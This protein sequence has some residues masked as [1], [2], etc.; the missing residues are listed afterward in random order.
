M[1]FSAVQK[2]DGVPLLKSGG[3]DDGWTDDEF[4]TDENQPTV[5][6][7]AAFVSLAFINAALKRSAWVC[8]GVAVI[9]LFLGYAAYAKYPPAASATTSVLIANNPNLNPADQSATDMALAKS[10]GV[11]QAA[12]K[13]LGLSQSVSS[14]LAAY[15]VTAS[16]DEVL[17]FQVSGPSSSS[18][19]QRAGA[20]ADAFLQARDTY[21]E[22]QQQLQVA[23]AQ[24]QL[25]QAQKKVES[26]SRQ[27]APL[28]GQGGASGPEL[29]TLQTEQATAQNALVTAQGELSTVQGTDAANVVA[30]VK[31]SQI[32]NLPTPVKRT[33]K[34]SKLFYLVLA[35]IAGLA[36]GA[37]IVVIQALVSSR[38]RNRDDIADAIGAPIL[39]S[40]GEVGVNWLP[41]VGRRRGLRA[42]DGRRV[43][44][45][46]DHA[47]EP[48]SSG[49]SAA[50]A[51][52]AVDNAAE[53]A[54]AV[55]SLALTWASRG[56][57]VVL[58]DLSAGAP[59][60]HQLRVK[61]PGVHRASARGAELVVSVPDRDDPAPVGPRP[62]PGR[63]QFGKVS[64]E[65]AKACSSADFLL[66]L[67]TL[68]PLS[69]SDHLGSWSAEAVA[70]V[71]A[72]Q[73]T[74]TRIRAVGEMVRLA[75]TRLVSVVLLRA[76]KSDESLGALAPES[77]ESSV[78][79]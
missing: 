35:C 47:V 27:I 32:L 58:A 8:C 20:V 22:S 61:G 60:A 1:T 4:S 9:G 23:L 2:K 37:A 56:K 49:R 16:S 25:T 29:T 59:A 51:V 79:L 3:L 50:L 17:V 30:M 68:D 24:Q 7:G 76:D 13:Q 65:L 44:V 18:A 5:E 70:V 72:G 67:V 14:F 73:S 75:G 52:V 21:L 78:S 46:L 31:G 66:T 71:S 45:H 54:P 34:N 63:P 15:T 38:L 28:Q 62:T 57:Q 55:V 64:D 33:F 42:L 40:T 12:L 77:A 74:S 19:V 53:V 6:R 41:R 39:L 26:L 48:A 69:G 11:A 10:Q 36:I 43:V